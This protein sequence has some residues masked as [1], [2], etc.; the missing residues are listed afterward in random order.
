MTDTDA[1]SRLRS[2]LLADD[3][4]ADRLALVTDHDRFAVAAAEAARSAGI[5][6]SPDAIR[7]AGRRDPL[8]I[9]R[10]SEM[11]VT[12]TRWPGSAWLPT[13]VVQSPGEL[14][15]DWLH[16]GD[17]SLEEPFYEMSVQRARRLPINS[18]LRVCTPLSLLAGPLPDD[19]AP[20]G[21]IF[22]MSRCGSTLVSQM[23]AAMPG[24]VVVSEAAALD[25]VV[26]LAH[27]HP[28]VSLQEQVALLR[29]MAA[30]LGRDRS[31]GRCR[32]VI[33][34]DSWHTL[35]LP[36]FRAAFPD[37]PWIFQFR[38][39]VEVMVSQMREPGSQTVPDARWAQL[40]GIDDPL[41]LPRETYVARVLHRVARAAVDNADLGGEIFVDY[42]ELP[43]AVEK[44]ILPHFGIAPPPE[45]VQAMHGAAQWNAK[46]PIF[47]FESDVEEKRR[48]AGESV[49][50]ATAAHLDPLHREL[51]AL[52]RRIA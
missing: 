32:Y 47:A 9:A 49:L 40:Y 20:D 46:A 44:R 19:A 14:G 36:L 22:H 52:A 33:K 50:N 29:G 2:L 48:S 37:T 24:S 26:Q 7:G 25:S 30:A 38:N 5:E 51:T 42:A 10:F 34:T 23:L 39:P 3:G 16:F 45:A 12:M 13:A 8:D 43:R 4:L 17:A 31:G 28:E 11:P 1:L 6:V 41:S 15:L 21:L 27:S 18:L 35:A